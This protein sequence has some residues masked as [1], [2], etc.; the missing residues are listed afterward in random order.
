MPK[1]YLVGGAVRDKLLGI[2]CKDYDFTFVLDDKSVSVSEGFSQM[3]DYLTAEGFKIF[4]ETPRAHTICA[5][6]PSTHRHAG[7]TADFVMARKEHGYEPGTRNPILT[8]GTLEDDLTRRDF[9]LNA[10]AEDEDGRIIDLFEGAKH[11]EQKLL[12]TPLDPT[13]TLM[14][15]PLRMLRAIRFSVTRGFQIRYDV[16]E[17]MF[18]PGLIE[19]MRTV[20]SKERVREELM[21]MFKHDTLA[22]MRMLSSIDMIDGSFLEA[23]FDRGMWMMPTFKDK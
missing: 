4:N 10:M 3:R 13:V 17:A 22:S 18:Q 19:H 9:T 16:F 5:K 20:V 21:K 15:D 23:V 14:D 1:I 6:F 2:K 11:L 8:I 12:V 7:L